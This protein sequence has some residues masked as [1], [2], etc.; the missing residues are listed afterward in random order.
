MPNLLKLAPQ[1]VLSTKEYC[2]PEYLRSNLTRHR[3]C[4]TYQWTFRNL[5]IKY[6][7]LGSS[8]KF[9]NNINRY[10]SSNSRFRSQQLLQTSPKYICMSNKRAHPISLVICLRYPTFQG[11]VM[12]LMKSQMRQ[13]A[14]LATSPALN[15]LNITRL[16]MKCLLSR[17]SGTLSIRS[18]RCSC[19]NNSRLISRLWEIIS[20][21]KDSLSIL[22][23]TSSRRWISSSLL[24]TMITR[25]IQKW[26]QWNNKLSREILKYSLLMSRMMLSRKDSP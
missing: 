14:T 1:T 8:N 17:K 3:H 26:K 15:N 2:P 13:Q 16:E 11:W 18:S 24:T 5:L 22:Q 4:K 9:N 23:W 20:S 19:I 12:P 6:R 21:Q 10:S 25:S 7:C